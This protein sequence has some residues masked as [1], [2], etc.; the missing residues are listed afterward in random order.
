LVNGGLPQTINDTIGPAGQGTN[1]S[2]EADDGIL[3]TPIVGAG[4]WR[5]PAAGG[6]PTAI[7]TLTANENSHRWP[8][9]L[10]GGKTLIFTAVTATD[11]AQAYALSLETGQR[12]RLLAGTAT[13]YLPTGHLVYIQNGTV[14]AVPFDPVRVEVTGAPVA[15]FSG[16]MQVKRLRNS[17]VSNLIPQISFSTVGT[18]AYVPA[19]PQ[20]RQ[21]A[22]M[23]VDRAGAEQPTGASGG[24][25][26]QPRL[27]PDG[28]RLAVTVSAD[29]DDVWLYD[30]TR[31]TWSRFTSQ[32]N[33]SFP[34]WSPDGRKLIYVSD[35]AGPDNMY[36]RP[37]DG[38]QPDERLVVSN[39]PNYPFSWSPDEVLAFVT[40]QA[41]TLQDIWTL[42]LNQDRKPT[43]LLQTPFSEG[44]PK[45]SPD[46]RWLAYVSNE[47]GRNEIYVRPYPGPGEKV[48]VST[49]G[50]NEPVWSA[51]TRELFFRNGDAMMVVD[52]TTAPTLTVGRPRRLFEGRYESTLALWPNYDVSSD[53]RRFVMIKRTDTGESAAQIN[54]VLNWFEELKRLAPTT[55]ARE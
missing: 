8:Q 37:M 20:P 15:V 13:R 52:I 23:W 55:S 2:W 27:S 24:A 21:S 41:Q 7:T 12:R 53:G 14:M 18:L 40:P 50:G 9:L 47:S 16:V 5:V 25:Y 26:F 48:T 35:K 29:R 44:A 30:L 32:G 28:R 34:L 31:Q 36:S 39:L 43:L 45:F 3:F 11:I 10:P 54:V 49:E 46:G 6:T 33:N 51:S 4:I 17:T 1:A 42:R 19:N 38:S 22:L